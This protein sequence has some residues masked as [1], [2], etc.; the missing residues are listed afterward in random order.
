MSITKAV[1]LK[2]TTVGLFVARIKP[3]SIILS[4]VAIKGLL[5]LKVMF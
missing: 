2:A 4:E 3:V 1:E 5:L